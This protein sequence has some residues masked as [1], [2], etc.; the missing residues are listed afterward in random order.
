M[1]SNSVEPFLPSA[2]LRVQRNSLQGFDFGNGQSGLW[3][4]K[5]TAAVAEHRA[6]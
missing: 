1:M 5:G 2:G 4:L 6:G 3:S